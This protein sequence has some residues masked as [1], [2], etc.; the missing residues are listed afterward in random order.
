M[1][2]ATSQA[3]ICRSFVLLGYFED[4]LSLS[5]L[6]AVTVLVHHIQ[7]GVHSDILMDMLVHSIASAH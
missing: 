1:A 2:N 3:W 4:W 6:L 7:Y 5:I